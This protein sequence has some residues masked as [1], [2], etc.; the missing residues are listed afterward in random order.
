MNFLV[1]RHMGAFFGAFC[2][3]LYL[4][5]VLIR[6]AKKLRLVDVP[7]GKLKQHRAPVPYLGGVAVY[8]SFIVVLAMFFPSGTNLL[9]F[10]LG[11]TVLLFVGLIDDF[12]ALSPLQK[13]GGQLV[14]VACF[15]KGGF[16]LKSRFFADY[17]NLFASGF[18]MLSVINAFNLVDVM[19]GLAG[20]LAIIAAGSFLVVALIIQQYVVS[21]FLITLLGALFAFLVYNKP[22]AKIYLGDAGSL[23]VG[24]FLAATPLLIRWTDILDTHGALPSFAQG[25]M[26]FETGIS[27]LVPMLFVGVPLLEV[28]SL[29]IIRKSKGLPFYCGGPQHFSSY[30]REKGW[31]DWRVLAFAGVSALALSFCALLFMTGAISFMTLIWLLGVFLLLWVLLV[32]W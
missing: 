17:I 1:L 27:A 32:F 20:M 23:F 5:P 21:I 7:D 22:S 26:L 4:V 25:N 19:D 8:V 28:F 12:S 31:S 9:W 3:G 14:A 6:A 13:M 11:T 18:W 29:I 10:I 24:G 2:L 16:S 30:L 15:L